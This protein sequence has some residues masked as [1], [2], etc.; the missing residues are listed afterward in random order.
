MAYVILINGIVIS[1]KNPCAYYNMMHT[2]CTAEDAALS[3]MKLARVNEFYQKA[4]LFGCNI[5]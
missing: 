3:G 5:I 2:S 1:A 4:N